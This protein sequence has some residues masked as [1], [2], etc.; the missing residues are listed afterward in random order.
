VHYGKHHPELQYRTFIV[1]RFRDDQA[2]QAR[3]RVDRV[4]VQAKKYMVPLLHGIQ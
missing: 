4:C 2:Q 1:R 3:A